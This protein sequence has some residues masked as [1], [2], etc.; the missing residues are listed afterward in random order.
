MIIIWPSGTANEDAQQSP[1]FPVWVWSSQ[2][3][4]GPFCFDETQVFQAGGDAAEVFEPAASA[5][6]VF[7]AGTEATQ[8][9]CED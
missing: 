1:F 2:I 8:V 7:D 4:H 5:S 6:Q 3:Q 9:H